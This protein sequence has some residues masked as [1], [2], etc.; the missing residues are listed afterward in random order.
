MIPDRT[1]FKERGFAIYKKP[2]CAKPANKDY[3]SRTRSCQDTLRIFYAP[4]PEDSA[5]P[6]PYTNNEN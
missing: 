5:V 2:E 6:P 4:W 3:D 1:I